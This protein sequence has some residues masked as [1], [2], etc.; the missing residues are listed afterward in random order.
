MRVKKLPYG[1]NSNE[2]IDNIT[3]FEMPLINFEIDFILTLSANLCLMHQEQ[4]HL[5]HV[6]NFMLL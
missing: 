6:H 5:Q 3:D 4:R 1:L 2:L